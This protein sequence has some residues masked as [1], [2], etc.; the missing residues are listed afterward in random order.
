M[1]AYTTLLSTHYIGGREPLSYEW[2]EYGEH[3]E[4]RHVLT[5]ESRRQQEENRLEDI[6]RKKIKPIA[7]PDA[8]KSNRRKQS[9]RRRMKGRLGTILSQPLG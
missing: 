1:P 5:K 3:G 7:D 8:E 9:A 6:A 2:K 4:S